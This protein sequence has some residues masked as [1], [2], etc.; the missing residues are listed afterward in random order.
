MHN[1]S[2]VLFLGNTA[3]GKQQYPL[4]RLKPDKSGAID[5]IVDFKDRSE[6]RFKGGDIDA[7]E[8]LIDTVLIPEKEKLFFIS[9]PIEEP[10]AISGPVKASLKVNINKP[11][12]DLVMD[13]Y[14]QTT[15]GKF[16]ALNEN[17]QRASYIN[18]REQRELLQ[19]DKEDTI[20]LTKTFITSRLLQKGSRIIVLIGINKS[21][22][23]QMNYGTGKDVSDETIND[24][25]V[26]LQIRWLNTSYIQFPIIK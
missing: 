3:D 7:F 15:D 13:I 21:P 12:I 8:K 11:D 17:M 4:L 19:T 24:A 20:N 25:K 18:D 23:W 2:L 6:I 26:P 5:Q 16:F 9:D 1:D 22:E 10:F 14:E